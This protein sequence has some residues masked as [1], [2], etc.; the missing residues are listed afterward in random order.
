MEKDKDL[1][2]DM[3]ENPNLTLEDLVSVGHSAESTR[4]LDKSKYENSQRVRDKFTDAQG[5]FKQNEFDAWYDQAA[6]AYQQITDKDT[7]LGLLNVTAFNE[8]DITV[9]PDK[10]TLNTKPLVSFDP[11]PDR[12]STGIF[13]IGKTSERTRTQSELAQAEKIL[14]NPVEAAQDP[15]KA[16]WG[17]SPND[18]WWSNF[19]DTQV[20]AQWDED[21]THIDPVTKQQVTHKKG[22]LKLNDNGT[23]YYEALDGRD[24]YGRQVLN[25]L[26]TIT[27]DGSFW[28][29]Y[30]FFD[31]DDIKEKS[32]VGSVAKN[33]TLVGS[34]FIPYVGWGIAGAS[35]ATQLVG[36]TGTLGKMLTGSD[37][38]TFSAMEGW[39]K[40]LNRQTATSEYAQQ[41]MLC[42]EN[43]INLIGDVTAQLREQ[44]AI[45]KF[46]PAMLGKGKYG[47]Q[48]ESFGANTNVLK[49]SKMDAL[50]AESTPNLDVGK[51]VRAV[52]GD[53]PRAA[54]MRAG[55]TQENIISSAA[56]KA[57]R[58]YLESYNK[59]GEKIARAYMVG[60]TV[61]D[62]YGEA[63]EAGA[64]DFEATMLTL[65][66]AA[67]ENKLLSSE[68]G[69]WIFPELKGERARLEQIAKAA[70]K[71]SEKLS[72]AGIES[73]LDAAGVKKLKFE[74]IGNK[75]ASMGQDTTKIAENLGSASQ[76]AKTAWMKKWFKAGKD[77]FDTQSAVMK[78][79]AGA[80]IANA[81]A[82]GTEE[83]SEELLKDFSTSCFNLVKAAQGSD[84][85][86]QGFLGTWDWNEALKRY[87]MNFFGG[88]VG[89]GINS[90]AYDYRQ[91]KDIANMTSEQAMQQLVWMDRNN[92]MDKFWDVVSKMTLGDKYH[93][94]ERDE[95]GNFKLGDENNN[96]DI[97]AKKAL[98]DQINLI[99]NI[100][101]VEG[102]N[103]DDDGLIGQVMNSLPSLN[104]KEILG[105]FRAN[106]LATSVTAGRYLK[107]YNNLC[108]AIV[109][110]A[111]ELR[112]LQNQNIDSKKPTPDQENAIKEAQEHLKILQDA[113]QKLVS[114][115]RTAEFYK[116]AMFETT[117]GV[118]ESF[119]APTEVQYM[120]LI[121]G[122]PYSLITE[123][124][125][126]PLRDK[127]AN[128]S[129]TE[130]AEQIHQLATI[131]YDITS[132]TSKALQDSHEM[133][134]KIKDGQ[135]KK[136]QQLT[137]LTNQ[138][139]DAIVQIAK[140]YGEN[141]TEEIQNILSNWARNTPS[142]QANPLNITQDSSTGNLVIPGA[143]ISISDANEAL[144]TDNYLAK[145]EEIVN[146]NSTTTEQ[147]VSKIIDT[148]LNTVVSEISKA[149]DDVINSRYVHPEVKRAILPVLEQTLHDLDGLTV[150]LDPEEVNI[151]DIDTQDKIGEQY[152]QIQVISNDLTSKID[153]IKELNY[154]PISENLRNFAIGL[155]T[156]A[157]VLDLIEGA[158][159]KEEAYQEAID[160]IVIDDTTAKQFEEAEKLLK[161]YRASI[162][163]S[164]T[165][166]AD[167]EN[168]FGYNKALNELCK[169]DQ[170]WKP[171][172][173]ID[174]QTADLALQDI[175]MALRR[176]QAIRGISDLNQGNKLNVQNYTAA[177]KNFILYNKM[178]KLLTSLL[179]E[180]DDDAKDV[181]AKWNQ[182]GAL[183]KL[184]LAI[185]SM[186]YHKDLSGAT[187]AERTLGLNTTQKEQ[188]EREQHAMD[189]A[190]YEFFQANK[191]K[192]AD[193]DQAR[194]DLA[195]FIKAA[196]L[197][198]Y[199]H[200]NDILTQSSEDIDDG[201]FTWWLASK[202]ALK[203]SDF[204]KVYRKVLSDDIAPIPTQEL[205]VYAAIASIY[206]GDVFKAFGKAMKQYVYENWQSKSDVVYNK[207]GSI[208]EK[209][210][211]EKYN[212]LKERG[213]DELPRT[214]EDIKAV[215][216]SDL[217]PSFFNILFIEGIPGSGKSTGV[218]KT[219][220]KLLNYL[221]PQLADGSKLF[222][223]PIIVSHSTQQNAENLATSLKFKDGA[224]VAAYGKEELLTWISAEYKNRE[225]PETGVYEYTSEDVFLGDD[226]VYHSKWKTRKLPAQ[227]VPSVMFIDEWSRYTQAEID[228]INRFA[229]ENGIQVIASGDMDQLSPKAVYKT[230]VEGEPDVQLSIARNITPRVPKLGVSMR[231]G[232]GQKVQNMYALL[233]AKLHNTKDPVSLYYV[234]TADDLYG[235][236][237]YSTD[238]EL[239]DEK[240]Q[241]IKKDIDKMVAKLD[242]SKNEKIGYIY[243]KKGT[244]L[245]NL[246]SSDTYK[247]KIDFKNEAAAQGNEARYYI[248]ENNRDRAQGR[249]AY[250]KS[251]YTGISRAEQA[252]IVIAPTTDIG[253]FRVKRPEHQENK[254]IPD[255]FTK[256]GIARFSKQRQALLDKIYGKDQDPDLSKIID[257]TK[258]EIKVSPEPP[259]NTTGNNSEEKDKQAGL[260]TSKAAFA[261]GI[262]ISD[263]N[264]TLTILDIEP[265]DNGGFNYKIDIGNGPV[266]IAEQTLLE[267]GYQPAPA[268]PQSSTNEDSSEN[269]DAAKDSG[270]NTEEG[271]TEAPPVGGTGTPPVNT[272][273]EVNQENVA[274]V[275]AGL[276]NVLVPAG[277]DLGKFEKKSLEAALNVN[278]GDID[279][280]IEALKGAAPEGALKETAP[281]VYEG[282]LDLLSQPATGSTQPPTPNYSTGDQFLLKK[283]EAPW[284]ISQILYDDQTNTVKYKLTRGAEEIIKN[285]SELDAL[286]E[287][288]L[289][290]K[291]EDI[292]KADGI[293]QE[294][295]TSD[296]SGTRKQTEEILEEHLEQLETKQPQLSITDEGD[297]NL[298]ITGKTFNTNYLGCD[299]DD[300]GN[301][302]I[303][304]EREPGAKRIDQAN[305]IVKITKRRLQ[306]KQA[307]QEAIGTLRKSI[308]FKSL[309]DIEE[310]IKAVL[311]EL[312]DQKLKLRWAFISKAAKHY[313]GDG[314][315]F[316]YNEKDRLDYMVD[317]EHSDVPTKMI[318]LLVQDANGACV[319]ELPM[320][321]LSSPFT[322]LYQLGRIDENNK[323]YQAYKLSAGTG[324]SLH[325]VLQDVVNAIN[326]EP[327]TKN[328]KGQI[329]R[330][331]KQLQDL[332]KLWQFT[333]DGVR[334]IPSVDGKPFNLADHAANLGPSYIK[335]RDTELELNSPKVDRIKYKGKWH[336]LTEEVQRKDVNYSSIME[337]SQEYDDNFNRIGPK[338]HPFVLRSD[339]EQYRDDQAMMDRYLEQ[340]NDP[341]LPKIVKMEL[342]SPPETSVFEY[343]EGRS[344]TLVY[345]YGN[346]FSAYRILKAIR[347]FDIKL[348]QEL[349]IE[350]RNI[351][352]PIMQALEAKESELK[353]Q[354]NENHQQY[355]SRLYK[356]QKEVL[357]AA[358][359][360][361]SLSTALFDLTYDYTP[362][363]GTIR[364]FLPENAMK[365][366]NAC[367]QAGITGILYRPIFQEGEP[368]SGY[369][370]RIKTGSNKYTAE[371]GKSYRIYSKFDPPTF[372]LDKLAGAISNWAN[373]YEVNGNIYTFITMRDNKRI[374][375]YHRDFYLAEGKPQASPEK[376]PNQK[377]REKYSSLLEELN[378]KDYDG[379]QD[380]QDESRF[381]EAI[382]DKYIETPGNIAV[383][384]NGKELICAQLDQIQI[385]GSQQSPINLDGATQVAFRSNNTQDNTY[386][387]T[388]KPA[389]STEN[390]DILVEVIPGENKLKF[391]LGMPNASLDTQ[392]IT[393]IFD[394]APVISTL[395]EYVESATTAS[396]KNTGNMVIKAI[397][398]GVDTGK[399]KDEI[400]QD[401]VK[402]FMGKEIL[403]K[404]FL[405][406]TLGEETANNLLENS[407]KQES[408][409][410][411]N[412][413]PIIGSITLN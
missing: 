217:V 84:V 360:V 266:S 366:Q 28:N 361:K 21:G 318:S 15:S 229:S 352:A 94:S 253:G 7:N 338:G 323:I 185:E 288:D 401:I 260:D 14:L 91:F 96:Q 389:N 335:Y 18:S 208:D 367:T 137:D 126:K 34:M 284:T 224:K 196:K 225:N 221:D 149:A 125:K 312:K 293:T 333:S 130:R 17:D 63:K 164:R 195:Q 80:M 300:Q 308:M 123:S 330:G 121:T 174:S 12:L 275:M 319:L 399:T 378:M 190:I 106:A 287:A 201:A 173:E 158:I 132:R 305:G 65:G 9:S 187:V 8:S 283:N 223:H 25:K 68:L 136:L 69:R 166:N 19:F 218:D 235:D 234:E 3:L 24:I 385:D 242:A 299:F 103:I 379:L 138:K 117:Y 252:S 369:G 285:E 268:A 270:G 328:S 336:D 57:V 346:E 152:E 400:V 254:L 155:G 198:Y 50:R 114:G 42:W 413:C 276:A 355:R 386:T 168:I 52:G 357:D 230:G 124:E 298:P 145:Y 213:L 241:E 249:D 177:N 351:T 1:F 180:D 71:P 26:N 342:L 189:D 334:L 79:T 82:E 211:S 66:Y 398:E 289:Y 412:V 36:L 161:L 341:N 93:T 87:G 151:Q 406:K 32:F 88:L 354:P 30:D 60:I 43:F 75:I 233:Q 247:D 46:V 54:L 175:N 320:L 104:S 297:I 347:N 182:S 402:V 215:L 228:L 153:A 119:I 59:V 316:Y 344:K 353:Q 222:D 271:S 243:Y 165:D 294:P 67:A 16:K 261:K 210:P 169:N 226:G 272:T 193:N 109:L 186:S 368:V 240:I 150:N 72:P 105:D 301:A 292:I 44:R 184:K 139:L 133:Y 340:L 191:D 321:S 194:E 246:L 377:L 51:M 278:S 317:D 411:P 393:E 324:K 199:S 339:S 108:K 391:N 244:K 202:A 313:S 56:D 192:L 214:N 322:A 227:D 127:Y 141:P 157:S 90:A 375:D 148:Y 159:K 311:P 49:A 392:A 179:N 142:T 291:K 408:E 5:N 116:D 37:S 147:K 303:P 128:W 110:Q 282:R 172:A 40:S 58:D 280:V 397:T 205:G 23:Y 359:G 53:D 113:R 358:D 290:T 118:S 45:F 163:A 407:T 309:A 203:S 13:R 382:R 281:G 390:V 306:T 304:Q 248:V 207:D 256:E 156:D 326:T 83:V 348:W 231:A 89:G 112:N 259:K 61:G 134:D 365:I 176:L 115:E 345:H 212:I 86:M 362:S 239:S 73:S 4:F 371:D 384:V 154:T 216:G 286:K 170:N 102:A 302:I 107:E 101:T 381:L 160:N 85:R 394:F 236:K 264:A 98:R 331:Y 27:T 120:E 310:D 129:K 356:A 237:V 263:G 409:N 296:T 144:S 39:S 372:K 111:N 31:S 171:L 122:K 273:W 337:L 131:F 395:N 206:N 35:V 188:I 277:K 279:A 245:Y 33:L 100:L 162:V 343:L 380:I 76:S 325:L 314:G 364:A 363:S 92:E 48:S 383:V 6:K 178:N 219:I 373:S 350:T 262:T 220:V 209:S 329:M 97:E 332:C 77:I 11:N 181:R 38:P 95:N 257:R 295:P 410:Q 78:G 20:L 258:E 10:R 269:T 370:Y 267:Q 64:T 81:L 405:K 327:S 41:N 22:E 307:L 29:Q 135:L 146:D 2:L 255:N 204:H 396:I 274:K 183:D 349:D 251:L 232:N 70:L 47:I 265:G 388:I 374:R 62:T 200:N 197:D 376:S 99:H 250:H 315:R 74:L 140:G 403:A 387:L 238:G 143:E 404:A 55:D 167:V